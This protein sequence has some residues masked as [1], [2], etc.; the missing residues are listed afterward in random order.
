MLDARG[1]GLLSA[2]VFTLIDIIWRQVT[3]LCEKQIL[4]LAQSLAS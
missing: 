2:L 1:V 4:C 3:K